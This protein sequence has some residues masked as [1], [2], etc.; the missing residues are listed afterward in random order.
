[1]QLGKRN[2]QAGFTLVEIA[3]VL[4][5]I[6]LIIAAVLTTQQVTLNGKI[7]NAIQSLKSFQAAAQSYNQNY[8]ALPGDDSQEK[9]RF[10]VLTDNGDG[11]GT[12]GANGADAFALTAAATGTSKESL[13]FWGAL[14]AANLIKGDASSLTAPG[15]AFGGVFAVQDGAFNGGIAVGTNVLCLNH[16]P[17]TAAIAIDQQLDDGKPDTGN[18]KGGESLTGAVTAA[19]YDSAK[20]YVL[21]TAL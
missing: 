12:V 1:M 10:S 6:G 14:R 5:I 15:N 4:V 9:S 13:L 8:G 11:N 21:C 19:A 17:G 2:R 18:I 16:V 3:V 20:N 7:T